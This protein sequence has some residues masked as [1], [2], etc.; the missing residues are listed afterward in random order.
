MS[1]DPTNFRAN[2]LRSSDHI[3]FL[4]YY[5]TIQQEMATHG[6]SQ[7]VATDPVSG[8]PLY[9]PNDSL[10][11][12]NLSRLA[13]DRYLRFSSLQMDLCTANAAYAQIASLD[14]WN[15]CQVVLHE[16]GTLHY[17]PMVEDQRRKFLEM[18]MIKAKKE[19][20]EM[21]TAIAQVFKYIFATVDP[22][23]SGKI[24]TFSSRTDPIHP[25]FANLIDSLTFL[26]TEMRGNTVANREALAAQLDKLK[27]ASTL[28]EFRFVLDVF[29][30][31]VSTIATSIRLYG[32]NGMLSNSQI[33]FKLLSK[34][35]ADASCLTFV[36]IQLNS[37]PAEIT[38]LFDLRELVKP[39]L[40][41]AV[42]P[43]RSLGRSSVMSNSRSGSAYHLFADPNAA[44]ISNLASSVAAFNEEAT[45]SENYTESLVNRAVEQALAS[46]GQSTGRQSA[47][48]S[49]SEQGEPVRQSNFTGDGQFRDGAPARNK[50]VCTEFLFGNCKHDNCR[51]DHP[52]HLA[53]S[54]KTGGASANVTS[55]RRP[56]PP[57]P[58]PNSTR[59]PSPSSSRP[60]S[61]L[62]GALKSGLGKRPGSPAAP[63]SRK[64][65][66]GQAYTATY[67]EEQEEQEEQEEEEP[68][69]R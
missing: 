14:N 39:E 55:N 33:H 9:I 62:R 63:S 53:N 61:P 12:S 67:E 60:N 21:T 37:Q 34:I 58:L 29:V 10:T 16:M 52:P 25:P 30:S 23:L 46:R 3:R 48:L 8:A 15:R 59:P 54:M 26:R 1:Y 57:R 41:R 66:F 65:Q 50:I 24:Q 7:F 5:E 6:A 69:R 11:L 51:F 56:A 13:D 22:F 32:G 44:S 38:T 17:D 47:F 27:A 19:T 18:R 28:E 2:R 43:L 35:N 49:T 45:S 42:D 36:R 4:S 68:Y 40:D 31:V 64:I 20:A